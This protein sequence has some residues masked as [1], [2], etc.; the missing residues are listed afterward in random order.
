MTLHVLQH[1]PHEG[2]GTIAEWA[3]DRGHDLDVTHL[4]DDEPLPTVEDV[5]WLVVLG[6]PMGVGDEHRHPYLV[7]ET[8]LIARAI[9]TGKPVLG[10]CLGAQLIADA[11]GAEVSEHRS[12]EIGWYPVEARHRAA[13]TLLGEALPEEFVPLHWHGDSFEVPEDATLAFASEAC[14]NQAFVYDDRVVGL[15]FHLECT[16]H[17]V[18]ELV[19]ASELGDE[20]WIQSEGV[21]LEERYRCEK[22]RRLCYDLLDAMEERANE[23]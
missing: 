8:E 22:L 7:D 5:D 23:G 10:I 2:P 18:Q 17:G 4:Y 9:T 11:L 3:A 12:T 13:D 1:V 14:T 15:Q 20:P 6:G 19:D 21:L 16:P